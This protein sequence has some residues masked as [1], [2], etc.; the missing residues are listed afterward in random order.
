MTYLI[1][2][3]HPHVRENFK[4][5]IGKQILENPGI[6]K[7][8]HGSISS[9]VVWLQRDFALQITGVF[10]TQEFETA[11]ISRSNLSLANFWHKYCP[12]LNH[13]SAKQKAQYQSSDWS[14]RP[15][16]PGQLDYAAN[17]SYFLY[18]IARQ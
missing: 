2:V 8:L 11:F 18:H 5:T 14:V 1:D 6:L 7:L 3:L 9:D 4:H 12:D 17:D 16:Q 13:I 10:D 15:L